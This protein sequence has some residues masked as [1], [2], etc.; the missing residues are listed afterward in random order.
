MHIVTEPT[1]AEIEAGLRTYG[2]NGEIVEWRR[3][4]S[5]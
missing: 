5:D 2:V 3:A 4:L 1:H